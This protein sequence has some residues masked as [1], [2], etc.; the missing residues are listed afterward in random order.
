M[1]FYVNEDAERTA[2]RQGACPQLVT[3]DDW[4]SDCPPPKYVAPAF[5]D[6]DA[7]EPGIGNHLIDPTAPDSVASPAPAPA[8][9]KSCCFSMT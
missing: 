3:C 2:I 9:H 5:A 8:W 4:A 6:L 7:V 1:H